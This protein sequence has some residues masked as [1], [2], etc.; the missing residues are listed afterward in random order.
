MN[1]LRISLLK[2]I[3]ISGMTVVVVTF[4]SYFVKKIRM[5]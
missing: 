2:L 5:H 3:L 4:I 1:N